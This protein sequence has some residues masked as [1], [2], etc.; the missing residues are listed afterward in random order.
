[1][2]VPSSTGEPCSVSI[3]YKTRYLYGARSLDPDADFAKRET[4][5]KSFK[6]KIEK[7][8]HCFE[9]LNTQNIDNSFNQDVIC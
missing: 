3:P 8:K 2:P 5:T 7:K 1:M 4:E 9:R 6:I